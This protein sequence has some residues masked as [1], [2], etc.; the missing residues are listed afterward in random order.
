VAAPTALVLFAW[1]ALF[2]RRLGPAALAVGAFGWLAVLGVVLAAVAPGGSYLTALPALAGAI[3]GLLAVLFRGGW[4][5]VLAVVLGAAVAVIV[6]LPTVVL[7]FP[8]MG[9]ALAAT[10]G[11]VT[12][13]LGLALVPVIDLLHPEAGGPHGVARLGAAVPALVALVAV[14]VFA[15]VGLRVD[16]FDAAHPA[17]TQLMYALDTDDG[18]AQWLSPEPAPQAWTRQYV[19]G[20]PHTV[21]GALPAFGA[22]KLTSGTAP[23]AALP[24]SLITL[25]SV[26]PN[27][28]GTRTMRLTVVPQ[29]PVRLLS[30]HVAEDVPVVAATA[31]GRP[32]PVGKPIGDGWGFGF[33]FHAPPPTGL[34]VTLTVRTA[35]PVRIRVMDGSDGLTGLPGFHPRPAGVGIAGSHISEMCAVTKT[36]QF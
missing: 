11:F 28:D 17:P 36:Y 25:S 30:L 31:G 15:A 34:D 14:V 10:G 35:A 1:Y 18:T 5:A 32:V 9:M 20:A 3:A 33:V 29:R 26:T 2:R 12:V 24:A 6:L 4:F 7:F 23:V 19:S 8:A 16:R 21:T 22:L 27:A 13:L